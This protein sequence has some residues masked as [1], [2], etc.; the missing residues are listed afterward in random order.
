MIR[1]EPLF[2]V[3]PGNLAKGK[4]VFS[5]PARDGYNYGS[6]TIHKAHGNRGSGNG[7]DE[8]QLN[9]TRSD[10]R[11]AFGWDAETFVFE[12]GE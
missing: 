6:I 5:G 2:F 12:E 1:A 7:L 3:P 9:A 8:A 4:L 10:C 11:S